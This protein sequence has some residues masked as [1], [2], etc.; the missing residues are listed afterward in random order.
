MPASGTLSTLLV[1]VCAL[2]ALGLA[3][4]GRAGTELTWDL[5]D[6]Y[7]DQVA[8]ERAR[9]GVPEI[10]DRLDP[11]R[12]RLGD[13]AASLREALDLVFEARKL[14]LRLYTYANL[15]SDMDTRQPGPQGMKQAMLQLR[16][17]MRTR[18]AW[19]DPEILALPAATLERFLVEDPGLTAYRRYLERLDARRPH[20][21]DARGEEIMG[22]ASLVDDD[23]DTIGG[24][25]L[26]AEIPWREVT[27]ADG[28]TLRV[29]PAGYTRGRALPA[30]ED[31]VATYGA[32]Y[33]SL[34]GFQQSLAAT[35]ASTVK[36]HVFKARVRGYGNTLEAALADSE[37][38]PAAYE[39]LVREVNAG[40]PTLHRYL[41][42][43][44][45][46]L[47]IP[48]LAYHDLYPSLVQEVADDYPWAKA[49]EEVL[50]ALAPMGTEYADYLRHAY[51]SRWVD[52]YPREGKRSGAYMAGSAYDVHPYMLLNHLEDYES[53]ST[54]AHESGH[55][56]HSALTN[57]A[58]PYPTADYEIFVAEV[59][60]VTNEWLLF[61]YS[62]KRAGSDDER[63]AILGQFLESVRTT[64]FRQTM[65]AE[66]ERTIHRLVEEGQPLSSERLNDAYLELL[67]RYHGHDQ[68]VCRVD[69]AYAVE[70]AYVP[71]FHYN[72]YVYA[73]ATSFI[74]AAAFSDNILTG[75][76][77]GAAAY[78]DNV[79][80]AGSSK[81]PVE[82]L[83]AGG[84]DLTTA[85]PAQS[86]IR[87]MNRIMDRMEE[88]LDRQ[89]RS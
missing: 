40:L 26:D 46:M 10:L 63:L 79:L 52:V 13:S 39:I 59:A 70:W 44:S 53:T 62:L 47:G 17:E 89:A 75:A 35:L 41:A 69:E 15:L 65:F 54:L 6:L 32:F 68:G 71:H 9:K 45:R 82:I 3:S 5:A 55:M 28:S 34:A 58:Q 78:V 43:R 77:G 83:K 1:V 48:D 42:L 60:S 87:A 57:R 61:E 27:L 20:T 33:A 4:T 23:G 76:N 56:M 66:F 31:R 64:V 86:L 24:L 14:G 80:K 7:P 74:A 11:Y 8:W 73:Y 12:G 21:L 85:A 36:N 16:A 30:R 25:L 84:V 29:D 88:I 38:D 49:T 22:L 2:G 50:A 37:V 72:Y 51:A 67:R 81:P 18:T 19:V